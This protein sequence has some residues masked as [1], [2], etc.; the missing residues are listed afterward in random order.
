MLQCEYIDTVLIYIFYPN[1]DSDS[2]VDSCY[3]TN[4]YRQ[5]FYFYLPW[6]WVRPWGRLT[7]QC[8]YQDNVL[9]SMYPEVESDPEADSCYNTN[10]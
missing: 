3:N 6:S 10:I 2:E 9:N 1:V 8:Q 7:L 4:I 5:C